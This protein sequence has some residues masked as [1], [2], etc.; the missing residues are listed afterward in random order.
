MELL[1]ENR[2]LQKYRVILGIQFCKH[3]NIQFEWEIKKAK[4]FTELSTIGNV[5]ASTT[6]TNDVR[7][8]DYRHKKKLLNKENWPL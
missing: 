2:G 6:G 4:T 8:V 7:E 5:Q 3:H 1:T